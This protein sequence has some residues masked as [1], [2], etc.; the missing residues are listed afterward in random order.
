MLM[1][2]TDRPYCQR[3]NGFVQNRTL[4][5]G[6]KWTKYEKKHE[7]KIN[8]WWKGKIRRKVRIWNEKQ[9]EQQQQQQQKKNN[10]TNERKEQKNI[11]SSLG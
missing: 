10:Q 6:K 7:M 9:Q 3:S 5:P 4:V 8:I 2:K 11:H 1:S